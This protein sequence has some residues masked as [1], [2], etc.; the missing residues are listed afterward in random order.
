[1]T[2]CVAVKSRWITVGALLIAAFAFAMS[3]WGGRWWSI[4][5]VS[6]GPY[7]STHC[8]GANCKHAGLGWIGGTERWVRVGMATWAGG[9][10]TMLSLL[11]VAAGIAARRVPRLAAKMTLV[12]I[13]TTLL[14][15]IAFIVQFPGV[16]GAT[17]DRGTWTFIAGVIIGL[18]ATVMVL[19]TPVSPPAP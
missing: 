1:M 12:A 8:F 19:R 6:I 2:E 4:D 9:V 14:A 5:E 3:V 15:G 17:L 7:G 16:A 13:A 10:L 11:G 18:I